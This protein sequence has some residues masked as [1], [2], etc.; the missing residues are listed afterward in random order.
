MDVYSTTQHGTYYWCNNAT[1][2][3]NVKPWKTCLDPLQ[4]NN[5]IKININ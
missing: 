3:S 1:N 4:S 2:I 5:K